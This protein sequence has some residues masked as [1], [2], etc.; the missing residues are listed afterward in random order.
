MV[1]EEKVRL[2]RM[3]WPEIKAAVKEANGIVMIPVGAVEEHGPHLP[4]G[5]DTIETAEIGYR[6]AKEAKVVIAPTIWYGQSRGFMGFPGTVCIR[7]TILGEFVKDVVMSLIKHGFDKPIIL[8]GHG[9]N[10]GILDCIA[11]EI[12]YETGALIS[13]IRS[14]DLATV[15]KPE[16]TPKYD[17]HGGSSETSVMLYLCPEDVH[18]D[19]FVDSK[20]ELELTKYGAVFPGPSTLYSKGPVKMPLSMDEMVEHGHHGDPKWGSKERGKA[21]I[22]VKSKALVDFLEALKQDK[23]K[24]RKKVM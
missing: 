20:P 1:L 7:P 5:T 11:E 17:G 3:S 12:H 13:H 16:G 23:I 15:P 14:W 10:Y 19:K 22:E 21:L 18:I 4:L 8:D 9:G 6:A 2:E 24:Y